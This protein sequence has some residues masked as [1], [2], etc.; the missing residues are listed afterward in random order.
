MVYD[1]SLSNKR[2][3]QSQSLILHLDE[4]DKVW[5]KSFDAPGYAVYSNLG[6]YIMF[7]GYILSAL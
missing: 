4:G 5:L 6:N 2:Q 7:S 1:E 3:M